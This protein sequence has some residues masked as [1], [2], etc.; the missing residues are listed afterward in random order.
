MSD[1]LKV[2]F[3][4]PFPMNAGTIRLQ[5]F[6]EGLNKLGNQTALFYMGHHSGL[7]DFRRFDLIHA[8]KSHYRSG[9]PALILR[10]LSF[11]RKAVLDFDESDWQIL[12]DRG[13][14][15]D[16]KISRF[17]EGL[18]SNKFDG[19]IAGNDRIREYLVKN[20][21]VEK[22][23]ILTVMSHGIDSSKFSPEVDGS[24]IRK[25][26]GLDRS[27]VITYM[28]TL[29]SLEQMSP[30][31]H[32]F[33]AIADEYKDARLMIVGDGQVK[34]NLIDLAES[35]RIRKKVVFT[36]QVLHERIPEYLA[37]SDILIS[38]LFSPPSAR[39][40][41][42]GTK[43]FEYM[44]MG[45][46]IIVA[47][48]PY[49]SDIYEHGRAAYLVDSAEPEEV[50]HTYTSIV[51]NER[52]ARKKAARARELAVTKYDWMVLSKRLEA[53]YKKLLSQ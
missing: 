40:G 21:G 3:L 48:T 12:V 30:V 20:L 53:V 11:F 52:E 8:L 15:R 17:I 26:L 51:E 39:R 46:P 32:G 5:G 2:A 34:Q 33:K 29:T 9:L 31:L 25:K 19:V 37:A 16:A 44:A 10:K 38:L 7:L 27:K 24:A 36:G 43:G 45:K 6:S 22:G 28:G 1:S 4:S 49:A 50:K 41:N 13:R 42:P 14:Y 23:N 18:I 35:L 47:N